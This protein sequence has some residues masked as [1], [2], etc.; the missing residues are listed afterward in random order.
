MKLKEFKE[1]IQDYF[2]ICKILDAIEAV[3]LVQSPFENLGD[4]QEELENEDR[5]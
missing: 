4:K 1:H 5:G 2:D 3:C